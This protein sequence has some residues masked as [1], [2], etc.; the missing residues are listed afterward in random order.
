[1]GER[2][3]V[4]LSCS[5]S[6]DGYL[7]SAGEER[8]LL[9]NDADFDRVDEV[10]ASCDAILVGAATVRNDDPRLQVRSVERRRRRVAAGLPVGPIKVT[11]TSRGDLSPRA[12]FFTLGDGDKLVYC[13]DPTGPGLESRIGGLAQVVA[14]GPDVRMDAL[15]AD[16]GARGVRRLMVEGGGSVHTQFLTAGVADELQLVVAPFF[17]GD[18]RARRFVGDGGFPWCAE[19]RAELVESRA[20]GDVALLRYALSDRFES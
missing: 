10:R 8:L 16:L 1:M 19:R 15:A 6:L 3:Y 18:S 20:I 7:D 14:L 13:P 5:V 12:R 4:L 9:S 17:V 11:L 2:P